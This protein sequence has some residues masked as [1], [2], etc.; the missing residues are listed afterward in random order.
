MEWT[1]SYWQ[2]MSIAQAYTVREVFTFLAII[3]AF[4][5]NGYSKTNLVIY[6]FKKL[7][8]HIYNLLCKVTS[9]DWVRDTKFLLIPKLL[10]VIWPGNNYDYI[11]HKTLWNWNFITTSFPGL[12][13]FISHQLLKRISEPCFLSLV[14][15]ISIRLWLTS[16]GKFLRHS[17]NFFRSSVSEMWI[18]FT[19]CSCSDSA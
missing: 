10:L 6:R 14:Q 1:K 18:P 16:F 7:W 3:H 12:F 5:R 11:L 4:T 9:L 13:P 19:L 15:G 2:Y 17:T 8:W